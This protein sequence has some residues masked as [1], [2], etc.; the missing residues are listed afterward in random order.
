MLQTPRLKFHVQT[1]GINQSLINNSLYQHK[2]I[3]NIKKL[4]R[5]AGKCDNQKKFKEI[6]ENYMVYTPEGFTNESHIS[7]MTSE[8]VKKTIARKSLCLFTK[9]LDGKKKTATRQVVASKSKRKT[10][11]CGTTP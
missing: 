7:T 5:Q 10:I 2:C 1:I 3:Y 9:I 4:Y 8:P 11:K 6:L